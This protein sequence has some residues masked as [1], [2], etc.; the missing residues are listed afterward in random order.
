MLFSR[1]YKE[2]LY[3]ITKPERKKFKTYYKIKQ[4]ARGEN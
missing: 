3:T 4:R 1:G 2:A